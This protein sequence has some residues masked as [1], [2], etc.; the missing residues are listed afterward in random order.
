SRSTRSAD[1][2]SIGHR[3]DPARQW[4]WGLLLS[5]R[6]YSALALAQSEGRVAHSG[7]WR[8]KALM[9]QPAPRS[10]KAGYTSH[11]QPSPRAELRPRATHRPLVGWLVPLSSTGDQCTRWG[12]DVRADL[13][14]P[15]CPSPVHGNAPRRLGVPSFG[16]AAAEPL[17]HN[18]A[19]DPSTAP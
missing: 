18:P 5:G 16:L 7:I 15:C 6:P 9:A 13:E 2:C 11:G 12:D 19:T 3:D 1:R 10:P 17:P 14:L 4:P 8:W